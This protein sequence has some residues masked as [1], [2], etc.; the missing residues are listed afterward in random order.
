MDAPGKPIRISAGQ[1]MGRRILLSVIQ[2]K[3][4]RF[5]KEACAPIDS[6]SEDCP[7]E[8]APLWRTDMAGAP[9]PT[10]G[11]V[12]DA[13][14]APPRRVHVAPVRG[15]CSDSTGVALDGNPA[16]MCRSA[17][18]LDYVIGGIRGRPGQL[19]AQPS[20]QRGRT[21]R[22][23]APAPRC[24]RCRAGP[25]VHAPRGLGMSRTPPRPAP[26]TVV[27]VRRSCAPLAQSL[28]SCALPAGGGGPCT[29]PCAQLRMARA[30]G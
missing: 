21:R 1:F 4:V 22:V 30:G 18:S 15:R 29:A 20:G 11:A 9:R 17:D 7:Y 3:L 25:A 19:R 8:P 13:M 14:I 6:I 10:A 28:A 16:A 2:R 27:D 12:A 5:G 23:H 26:V 24:P